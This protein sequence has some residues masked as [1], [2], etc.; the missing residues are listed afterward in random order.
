MNIHSIESQIVTAYALRDSASIEKI[1]TDLSATK[2][3]MDRWFDKYL[4]MFSDKIAT[5]DKTDPIKKL[6]DK[7][8][9]EYAK[10]SHLIRVAKNYMVKK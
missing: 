2:N 10:V 4:D 5:V 8:F 3:K 7:K 9:N 1:Y 6:Y